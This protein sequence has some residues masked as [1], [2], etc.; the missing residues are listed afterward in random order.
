MISKFYTFVIFLF[1]INANA[2]QLSYDNFEALEIGNLGGDVQGSVPGQG[3]YYT[4]CSLL[5]D[6]QIIDSNSSNG[7]ALQVTGYSFTSDYR[8]AWSN[9][10]VNLWPNRNFGNNIVEV[11]FDFFT[12]NDSGIE[13][14]HGLKILDNTY[15]KILAGFDFKTDTNKLM[16]LVYSNLNG[17]PTNN[18]FELNNTEIILPENTWVRLGMSFNKITGEARFK[19]PGFDKVIASATLINVDPKTVDY[20]CLLGANN[21]NSSVVLYDNVEM[22][23]T[24]SNLLLSNQENIVENSKLVTF[25]PNPTTDNIYINDANNEIKKITLLDIKGQLLFETSK[26]QQ[27][28]SLEK[29]ESGV[30]FLKVETSKGVKVGKLI[31]K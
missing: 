29:F 26:N 9:N 23:A 2:Q 8:T 12:G 17:T 25:Y 16:G 4:F 3:G 22:R 21:F 27:P 1:V 24:A 14:E 20:F 15:N 19:G 18:Y 31:K 6:F 7:K 28:I 30:Y 13:S 11:E 5:S 10:F